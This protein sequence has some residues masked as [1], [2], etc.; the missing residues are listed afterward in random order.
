VD[1]GKQS[2]YTAVSVGCA[3]C[4]VEVARDRFNQIDY[5][6]QRGRLMVIAEKWKPARVLAESNAMGTPIIEM[7]LR[8]G[9]PV[10]AFDTTPSSKPP[11]IENLALVFEREEFQFVDDPI[12]RG[13]LEAYERKISPVTGRS[14]YSAPEGVHD[15]TV[16]ARALMTRAA[17]SYGVF[18]G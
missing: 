2:D 14:Q 8:D 4:K 18:F 12:W 3:D 9:L 6:F 13:E 16:M 5:V 7:L 10:M 15:D 11:L 17:T 1:W